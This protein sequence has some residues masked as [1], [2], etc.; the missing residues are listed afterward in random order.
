MFSLK[1]WTLCKVLAVI[2]CLI[3]AGEAHYALS[4][5]G[6]GSGQADPLETQ[7]NT[8]R[9][10]YLAGDFEA[11]K[12][13]LEKLIA[14][15]EGVE[16]RD[17]FK[18]TTY[19]LAGATYEQLKFREL[20]I[21]YDCKAKAILGAGKT[22]EGIDLKT[23]KYYDAD[24]GGVIAG[25]V[26]VLEIQFNDARAAYF[27]GNFEVAKTLLEKL[28]ADLG[29][30][31][32]QDTFKGTTY[33]LAGATYEKLKFREL[34]IK[35]Y[36]KAKAILGAGKTIEGLDL[37][38]LKYYTADCA[39]AIAG[40][41]AAAPKGRS[42]FG[43]VF[44]ILL[45]VA[46]LGCVV[47]YL[48]FSKNAPFKK[49]ATT[50]TTTFKSSCFSTTWH[51]T[52]HSEWSGSLGDVTLTPNQVPQPSE[53]N[54]WEDQVTY[55]LASSGGGTLLSVS[56]ILDITIGGGD[57]AKRHDIVTI[58]G[59]ERLNQSNSFSQACSSPG[60]IKYDNVYS[61]SSLGSFTAKHKVELSSSVGS[62]AT[63]MKVIQK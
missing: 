45:S 20:A 47:W 23:L 50:T 1:K 44:G 14:D 57:N 39:A 3:I 28:I 24:C 27:A 60:T 55:T 59:V 10:A 35:Y 46:I 48:F 5:Q 40:A 54:G 63:S 34:A 58:D 38:K 51:F 17:T 11:A 49:K 42:F 56:L 62:I 29:V 37:K 15:L 6:Q 32:G 22:I 43:S 33:L 13:V 21:K 16:G 7:F 52:I 4:Q 30:I 31:E 26:G 41:V 25:Q 19:L 8:A 36:C 12:T 53:N 18:G 9:T 61:R 2:L